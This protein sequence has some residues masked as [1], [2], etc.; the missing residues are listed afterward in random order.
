MKL[1][2]I[3][4]KSAPEHNPSMEGKFYPLF[5]SSY[6][7]GQM[8]RRDY[9]NMYRSTQYTAITTIASSLAKLE[10]NI[11][12]KK[13]SDR[14]I[15]HYITNLF[16]YDFFEN[17][18]SSMLLTGN[19]FEYKLLIGKRIQEFM[20]LRSDL[21]QI[22]SNANGT[23]KNYR[24]TN[25]I[26]LPYLT[27]DEVVN[28]KMYSPF[29][30]L[31]N[32]VKGVSPMQAVAL[33]SEVDEAAV[34]HNLKFFQNWGN[35]WAILKTEK[36]LTDEQKKRMITMWRNEYQGVNNGHRT[37]I[38]DNGL[39]FS[40]MS[41]TQKEMDFVESR[42][43]T[44]DEI[45]SVYKV[46]KSIIGITDDV[47]RASAQVAEN[48]FY[49]ICIEPLARKI[50]QTI[51]TQILKG[52]GYFEFINVVPKD[53]EQLLMDLNAWVITI[54]EYRKELWY[55]E[56]PNWNLLKLNE[57]NTMPIQGVKKEVVNENEKQIKSIIRKNT[58]GTEEWKKDLWYKKIK[59]TDSYE[60]KW[61]EAIKG[62]FKEQE[63]D[64]MKQVQK[65]IKTI[66]PKLNKTKYKTLWTLALTPLMK[67]VLFS[68]GN[69][70]LTTIGISSVFE[71]WNPIMNKYIKENI[72]RIAT[73]VD[74]T[75]VDKVFETIKQ[76]NEE[77]LWAD[78][79]AGRVSE[80][81]IEFSE[82]RSKM[83]ARTEVTRASNIASQEAY[84][85]GGIQYKEWLA[86]LDWRTS[87]ICQALNWKRVPID[88]LFAK[89]WDTV[90]WV[91]LDYEDLPYC[92]AHCNC[93]STI[94]AVID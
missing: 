67:D 51:N 14:V 25:K 52:D 13:G 39:D 94:I 62:I 91:V 81:F 88:W 53:T 50:Q 72:D 31:T 74:R 90:W 29:D 10:W 64:I 73:D 20:H 12:Q 44:R 56:I 9:L 69:E 82:N 79:I 61:E 7:V 83:I 93:R 22:E 19:S 8:T 35:P 43:Y 75:T 4:K 1:F 18:T 87:D 28:F 71:I 15:D 48:T 54:N 68:E 66:K 46:P 45:L 16:N 59:R 38:L 2:N 34:R 33:Q 23:F 37:A 30:D 36:D 85:Q 21:L 78:E 70:A 27:E 84:K 42:R 89:K 24:Y 41:A 49:R 17:V 63:I 6:G 11:V 3:F 32:V 77:G 65:W 60:V 26:N 5:N 40:T 80:K 86:E 92:P 55:E 58:K 57:F 47:N 76:A